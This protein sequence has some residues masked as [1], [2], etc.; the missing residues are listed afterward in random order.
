MLLLHS[1]LYLLSRI[2]S[3]AITFG[4]LGLYT[5]LLS[6]DDYGLYTLVQSAS[7]LVYALAILW[8]S[9]SIIRL[10]DAAEN[11]ATF[12]TNVSLSYLGVVGV[13]T[14]G[15]IV[16]LIVT[17]VGE[18]PVLAL[19]GF[20]MVVSVGWFELSTSLL[21]ARQ[22]PAEFALWG[23]VRSGL[24]VVVG[25][26]LAYWG[27]GA[28]GVLTG[29]IVAV[30]LPGVWLAR[31]QWD[32]LDLALLN[33]ASIRQ[34]LVYGLPLALGIG[35]NGLIY[36]A[37]RLLL[38]L[39]VNASTAGLYG[40]SF[41]LADRTIQVMMASIGAAGIPMAVSAL[42]RE[43][44][45][46][47][48]RQV[49]AN[50][51]LLVGIGLPAAVGLA[52]VADPLAQI[53][54]GAE[55]HQSAASLLPIIATATFLASLRANGIDPLFQLSGQTRSFAVVMAITA[56][57]A[58]G[59]NLLWIPKHGVTGAACA[60]LVAHLVGVVVG[61]VWGQRQ[62]A[63]RL[64][65]LDLAKIVVACIVMRAALYPLSGG[66]GLGSL[67][68]Q[69]VIGVISYGLLLLVLNVAGLR[70]KL[71]PHLKAGAGSLARLLAS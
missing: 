62:F 66:D 17:A 71:V 15:F 25:S 32:R 36:T 50:T 3:A 27:F 28:A 34:L 11:R 2:A 37:D 16:F 40:A 33:S 49:A 61:F 35:L 5:R 63:F 19:L 24:A 20:I 14:I 67:A 59:L 4:A 21:I 39:L 54:I 1:S 30:V 46:V 55:F 68:A 52:T 64:P 29:A 47:A 31:T 23:L 69:V 7:E 41:V 9:L 42:E 70:T 57:V 12:L 51:V 38:G 65:V 44:H 48:A 18:H 53:V 8:I 22:K 56:V 13:L 58:I 6:S 43:S 45:A 26:T 60:T 10:H